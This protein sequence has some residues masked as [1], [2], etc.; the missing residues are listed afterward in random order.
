MGPRS[1]STGNPM[2]RFRKCWF[3]TSSARSPQR[4]SACRFQ[5]R[6]SISV[7]SITTADWKLPRIDCRNWFSSVT[8]ELRSLS[9]LLMVSSSSLVDWSSSFMVSS[10]S[11][12]ECSSS[13]VVS[14]SSLV[15]WNS[16]LVVSSSSTV[17][18]SSSYAVFSSR[19]ESSRSARRC[20]YRVASRNEIT[21]PEGPSRGET[22]MSSARI[23]SGPCH[24]TS[25]TA[26]G[27]RSR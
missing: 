10:S 16:S 26:I 24:G 17:D 1:F 2:S 23:S 27:R 22:M 19:R 9:S 25:Y 20:W 12:V 6:T 14:S 3:S 15:D 5:A 8:S 18:C 11:L 4:S 21:R 13:L 7:P